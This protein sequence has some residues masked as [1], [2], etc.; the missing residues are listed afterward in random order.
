[1]RGLK[2]FVFLLPLLL[3]AEAVE[4]TDEVAELRARLERLERKLESLSLSRESDPCASTYPLLV[5][6]SVMYYQG[7]NRDVARDSTVSVE[8]CQNGTLTIYNT[9]GY[10]ATGLFDIRISANVPTKDSWNF[11]C[12]LTV[13]E[14]HKAT[15]TLTFEDPP[16]DEG[17][18]WVEIRFRDLALPEAGT[19]AATAA[20]GGGL[21][22]DASKRK[23]SSAGSDD[24][25]GDGAM[26]VA[27]SATI[28]G[29]YFYDALTNDAG[30]YSF[31]AS[32]TMPLS[33]TKT[34]T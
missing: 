10:E 17:P 31:Y 13:D 7:C 2:R 22:G 6:D 16:R 33:I 27:S 25:G 9:T 14:P 3:L 8:T 4:Q 5:E 26:C 28:V 30:V 15:C 12:T 29:T 20:G 24:D 18:A 23:R 11:V 1:M 19:A 21:V 32:T 34:S